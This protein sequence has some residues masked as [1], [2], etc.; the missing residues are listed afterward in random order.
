MK[1]TVSI[2]I[3]LALQVDTI[4]PGGCFYTSTA[5]AKEEERRGR[6][7]NPTT[8]KSEREGQDPLIDSRVEVGVARDRGGPVCTRCRT[9]DLLAEGRREGG[10]ASPFIP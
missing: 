7:G 5:D 4:R 10:R 6:R 1:A 2:I 3:V 8:G 9:V